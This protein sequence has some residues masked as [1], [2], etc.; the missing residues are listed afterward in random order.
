MASEK[1]M[2]LYLLGIIIGLVLARLILAAVVRMVAHAV[3][4]ARIRAILA[5][6]R[7]DLE[8]RTPVIPDSPVPVPAGDHRCRTPLL[9]VRSYDAENRALPS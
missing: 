2:W 3:V 9:D 8:G 1:I 6:E 4:Y 5:R 7:D